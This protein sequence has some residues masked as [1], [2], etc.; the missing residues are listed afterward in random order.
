V[1]S[2]NATQ[3]GVQGYPV[4]RPEQPVVRVSWQE[5]MAF[6]RWLSAKTGAAASLPTEAQWEYAARA[7]ASG[8]HFFKG[9]DFSAFANLADA[10]L[11]EFASDVWDND[12]PLRDATRYDEW[13]PKDPRFNDGGLLTVAPGRYRPN[14]WGLHDVYGNAAEWTRSIYRPYPY[15]P[16]DGRDDPS[17]PG[18]RVVR[19]GSWRDRP[20]RATSSF[21]LA[22]QPYQRVFNVGFRIVAED[23]AEPAR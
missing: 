17:V 13:I 14:A 6:C 19:G 18:P 16:G 11:A 15:D 10:K 22:Y 12:K 7:G 3:Y 4:N 9:D 1:E 20:A 23:A 5:A 2:K 8:P 21:R